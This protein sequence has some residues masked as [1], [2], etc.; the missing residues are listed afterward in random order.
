MVRQFSSNGRIAPAQSHEWR[1]L[2]D[3]EAPKAVRGEAGDG[4]AAEPKPLAVRSVGS[5][6]G[7]L[8]PP[9]PRTEKEVERE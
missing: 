9:T 2:T 8:L 5:Y 1:Y 6:D 3:V 7:S 4:A